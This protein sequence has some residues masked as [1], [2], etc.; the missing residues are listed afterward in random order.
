MQ[1]TGHIKSAP[2]KVCFSHMTP[3][4]KISFRFPLRDRLA[5]KT[6]L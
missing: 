2:E 3:S 6:A 4:A 5:Q 1:V